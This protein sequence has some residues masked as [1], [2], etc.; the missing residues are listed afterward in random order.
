MVFFDPI[1]LDD[2]EAFL[3]ENDHLEHFEITSTLG[4][5][6]C[7]SP[8]DGRCVRQGSMFYNLILRFEYACRALVR[9]V[10]PQ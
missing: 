1:Y 8:G 6:T 5:F 10:A 4:R 7:D 2:F 9:K 3:T